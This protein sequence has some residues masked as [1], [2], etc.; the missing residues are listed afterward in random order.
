MDDSRDGE[1]LNAAECA[2]QTGL[3]VRALRVY[4]RYGLIAPARQVNGW[5]RYGRKELT[6]LNT[7]TLLKSLGLTL[8]QIR[9]LIHRR[10]PSL[11]SVLSLQVKTWK[12]RKA[13][14]E[15]GHKLAQAAL[16]RVRADQSLSVDELGA[17]VRGLDGADRV[18]RLITADQIDFSPKA[19]TA[20]ASDTLRF[21]LP[22]PKFQGGGEPLKP[23][24]G[25][26]PF[27]DRNGEPVT[28]RGVVFFNPDDQCYQAAP[29]DGQAVVIFSPVTQRQASR[30]MAKIGD[31]VQ[32][33]NCLT[34][35]QFKDVLHFAD[36]ALSIPAQYNATREFVAGAMLRVAPATGIEAYGLHRRSRLDLCEAVYVPGAGAF[37]GP[38]ATPQRF[39]DGAV[40]V[41][42]A[43]DAHLVQVEVFEATY[44]LANGRSVRVKDLAVQSPGA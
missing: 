37:L 25:A 12:Q 33:P 38:A 29:G 5:R 8:A 9:D 40:I 17:L 43:G 39:D 18:P 13:E 19:S 3:T 4:E 10:E 20:V 6:R 32:D 42:H 35:A 28:G 36:E 30:L 1:W 7:V 24:A 41:R 16:K 22:V 21:V 31:L 23:P 27:R 11:L 26:A 14:A 2:V 44:K 15:Q 34:L